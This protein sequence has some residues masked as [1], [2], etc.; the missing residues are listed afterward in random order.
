VLGRSQ[1]LSESMSRYLIRRI[2]ETPT[3]QADSAE[4]SADAQVGAPASVEAP[5][6]GHDNGADDGVHD[7]PGPTVRSPA[8]MFPAIEPST[9]EH[10]T[11]HE[12]RQS[13]DS[14]KIAGCR[15]V[16]VRTQEL[17]ALYATS[18]N[19]VPRAN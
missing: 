8:G 2:E 6:A 13:S 10:G 14:P 17:A 16:V 4:H 12:I 15:D 9:R 7:E 18:L 19:G 5:G 11:T 3:I 1:S